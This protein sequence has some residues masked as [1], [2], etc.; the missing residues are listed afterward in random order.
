MEGLFKVGIQFESGDL[1][2]FT[3]DSI[4]I[5][6]DVVKAG[7]RKYEKSTILIVSVDGVVAFKS[8]KKPI[9]ENF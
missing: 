6:G 4:D 7:K 3:T 9:V 1:S 2:F 5:L 8:K